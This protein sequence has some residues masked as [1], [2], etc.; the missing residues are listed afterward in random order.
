MG[1]SPAAPPGK[2]EQGVDSSQTILYTR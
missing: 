1:W 2:D